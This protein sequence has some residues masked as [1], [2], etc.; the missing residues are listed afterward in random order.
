M[1]GGAEFKAFESAGWAARASTY[2]DLM[3]AVTARVTRPLLDAAGVGAGTR[4]LDAACGPGALAATAAARG[5][6][7]VG[8]DLAPGMVALARERHPELRFLEGDVERLPFAD[9]A[10]DAVVAGFLIHHLP[11]PERAVSEFARVLAPGGRAAVT[12]WARPERM[13]LIGLVD[14]A[15][16]RAGA[17]PALGVPEGPDAFGFAEPAQLAALL[18]GA[19]FQ[20]VEARTLAFTHRAESADELWRGLLGGTVRT[21]EQTKA[22]PPAVRERTR[23]AFAQLAEAHRTPDGALHVPVSAVLAAGRRA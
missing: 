17:E 1:P 11:D 6:V 22:Q 15:I 21:T 14:D 7:P 10:F 4:L 3:G 16:A 5:A 12:V 8:L 19:G 18:Q 23:E 2:D 9:G 13:R 20:A